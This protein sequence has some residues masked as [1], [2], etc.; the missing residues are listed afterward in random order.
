MRKTL[1]ESVHENKF[2]VPTPMHWTIHRHFKGNL[3]LELGSGLHS[4]TKEPLVLYRCLYHNDLGAT[5]LR[6]APSFHGTTP[7]GARRFQPIGTLQSVPPS[8]LAS[9]PEDLR[10]AEQA[11]AHTT[12]FVLRLPDGIVIS[13]IVTRTESLDRTRIVDLQTLPNRRRQ[14]HATILLR[15][16]M[17]LVLHQ[18]G[19]SA[20]EHRFVSRSAAPHAL[21]A[22]CGFQP[23]AHGEHESAGI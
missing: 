11:R 6:P 1:P 9:L 14:G 19:G 3:Y 12:T 10:S 4:E 17:G 7:D 15:A 2:R 21:F 16:T 20:P 5:W 13:S 8:S 22:A 23:T 18:A